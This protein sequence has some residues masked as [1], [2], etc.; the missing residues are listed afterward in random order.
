MAVRNC[1]DELMALPCTRAGA[2]PHSQSPMAA[3]EKGGDALCYRSGLPTRWSI[4]LSHGNLMNSQG[5][6]GE[7]GL[8]SPACQ[9]WPTGL[10]HEIG[11]V[12]VYSRP[13]YKNP[14]K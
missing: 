13:S 7:R 9:N 11:T 5:A 10:R 12:P 6:S 4:S 2:L 14:A 1:W 8:V 3:R